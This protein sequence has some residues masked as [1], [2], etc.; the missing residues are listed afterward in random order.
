M[1]ELLGICLVLTAL[2]AVNSLTSLVCSAVWRLGERRLRNISAHARA[3][4]LFGMRAIPPAVALMCAGMLVIPAYVA[5]EPP[6]TSETVSGKLALLAIASGGGLMFAVWRALRS[7]LATRQLLQAWLRTAEPISLPD[8]NV[9]TFRLEH[10]FP[11]IAVV[12]NLK[13]RLFVAGK[14]LDVLTT[15]ELAAAV[16]HE[17]GH[18]LARD[19][20]KRFVLRACR[21]LFM[22]VPIGRSLDAAWAEAAEAAADEHAA[23][24]NPDRALNLAS[25]LVKIARMIP[26][27]ARAEI[28]LGSY[29][30]GAEETS[31]V[32]ARIKRL[33]EIASQEI[34][35]RANPSLVETAQV[36]S[37]IAFAVFAL[38]AASN[39]KV[40]IGVHQI[41]ERAV[42]LLC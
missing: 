1:Y 8:L 11:I 20:L 31:G 4:F 24:S 18:L 2:L 12:G 17:H 23:A 27:K 16:A 28:P 10:S 42:S 38:T 34:D 15:E 9:P 41:I 14:V 33:L 3:D 26:L 35:T 22:L 32:K 13:P 37:L 6:V 25:A 30:I 7:W 5:Y 39:P 19:N 36:I 29:L 40:L 21:D